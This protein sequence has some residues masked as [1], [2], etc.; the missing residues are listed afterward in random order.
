[1]DFAIIARAPFTLRAHLNVGSLK[2]IKTSDVTTVFKDV[3]FITSCHRLTI[4]CRRRSP[5]QQ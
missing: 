1:M 2:R 5:P 3:P 4:H